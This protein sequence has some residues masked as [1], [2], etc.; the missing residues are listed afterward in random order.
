MNTTDLDYTA[1]AA[2]MADLAG[3]FR[4]VAD[5]P[6]KPRRERR[7]ADARAREA[8]AL[9]ELLARCAAAEAAGDAGLAA[10][11]LAAKR[12]D[13]AFRNHLRRFIERGL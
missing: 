2:S 3:K 5:R 7:F 12:R 6:D 4:T 13:A 9:S 1:E 11:T 8:H 10:L